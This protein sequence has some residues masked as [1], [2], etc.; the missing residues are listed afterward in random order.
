MIKIRV[1][2]RLFYEEIRMLDFIQDCSSMVPRKNL[3]GYSLG[4]ESE[5]SPETCSKYFCIM[6]CVSFVKLFLE[7]STLKDNAIWVPL[8]NNEYEFVE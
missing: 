4:I 7:L 6:F 5:F 1:T 8:L 2:G 3:I